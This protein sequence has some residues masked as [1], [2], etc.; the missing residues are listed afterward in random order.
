MALMPAQSAG[1]ALGSESRRHGYHHGDLPAALREATL[2][3]V[4]QAG[5]GGFSL[6]K[7]ARIAGVSTG[8]PYQ[9]Y[10][11]GQAL[12]A[13]VAAQGYRDV[14]ATLGRISDPDPVKRLG[15]LAAAHTRYFRS[16]RAMY[17]VMCHCGLGPDV[18][19]ALAARGEQAIQII[20]DAA[21]QVT[22][23]DRVDDL[24]LTTI[25]IAQGFALLST[26]SSLA[27]GANTARLAASAQAAVIEIAHATTT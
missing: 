9:H 14:V 21:A 25:A 10:Q 8:A 17:A 7:A 18:D 11:D 16:H 6:S 3:I 4:E 5:V 12:L 26:D 27:A 22:T 24:T 15:K 19:P 20:R 23:P 2:Q 13:D 1:R